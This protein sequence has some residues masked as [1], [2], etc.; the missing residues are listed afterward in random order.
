MKYITAILFTLALL[1]VSCSKTKEA[2]VVQGMS[3]ETISVGETPFSMSEVQVPVFPDRVFPINKYGAR[4]LPADS[5][6]YSSAIDSSRVIRTNNT[7][8]DQAIQ[9]CHN[10]GGGHIVIPRGEWLCSAVYL[11]SNCDLYLSEGAVLVFSDNPDDYLEEVM[12]TW[13]GIECMNYSPLIYACD[14]HNVGISGTGT[15][16]PIMTYWQKWFEDTPEHLKGL[17]QLFNWGTFGEIFYKRNMS[18]RRNQL[19]PHLIQFYQCSNVILQD[20]KIRESPFWTI[21]MY[22]CE[23]GLARNLDVSAHGKDNCGIALEMTRRFVVEDC[24]F[25]QSDD[26]IVIKS[27]RNHEGWRVN[28]PSE[29]IVVRNC[30]VK[31]GKA[32]L[33][34]GTEL[35]AGIRNVYMHDCRATGD[36]ETMFYIKTNNRRGAFVDNVTMERCE[37]TTMKRGLAIDTDVLYKWRNVAQSFKDSLT[38]IS[39]I[40]MRDIKC[41]KAIGL[42]DLN[43]DKNLPVKNVTVSNIKIDSISSFLS[44]V[45]NV[46]GYKEDSISYNWYG[47]TGE[48]IEIEK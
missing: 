25:D 22:R 5:S 47:H 31:H 26:A 34:I 10:S 15:L 27:G 6:G 3:T 13:E 2:E 35:S 1:S 39:N 9:A 11:K 41:Q 21:H 7:A 20:F 29:Y 40:T 33:G 44:H 30:T 14:S 32:F 18:G 8:I 23:E 16:R 45:A 48:R 42:V 24:T 38:A 43:G 17:R 19:R 12:S 28:Q 37:A 4:A 36:V 46:K